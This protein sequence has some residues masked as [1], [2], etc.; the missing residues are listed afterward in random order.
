LNLT[1]MSVPQE[2][3]VIERVARSGEFRAEMR[4][5]R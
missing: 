5:S 1:D 3:T 4:P 2:I